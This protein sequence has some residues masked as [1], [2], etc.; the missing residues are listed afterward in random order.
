[1]YNYQQDSSI[2]TNPQLTIMEERRE[3][4]TD[5]EKREDSL[6]RNRPPAYYSNICLFP[7]DALPPGWSE[8]TDPAGRVYYYNT[9][10]QGFYTF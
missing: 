6:E 2:R 3:I 5:R 10:T 4:Q 8:I 1:M 9:Y 7:S